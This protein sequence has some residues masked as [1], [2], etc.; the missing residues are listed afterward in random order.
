MLFFHVFVSLKLQKLAVLLIFGLAVLI[1][2]HFFSEN[3]YIAILLE[4]CLR[5][6]TR[7][8]VNFRSVCKADVWCVMMKRCCR[9]DVEQ[10]QASGVLTKACVSF[11]RDSTLPDAARYVQDNIRFH[12]SHLACLIHDC[13]AT[14]SHRV[15][16]VVVQFLNFM[17]CINFSRAW[18]S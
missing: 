14:V 18:C 4:R 15:S 1:L 9:E 17:H 3:K 13:N 6:V 12:G 10:W 8:L 16:N 5:L 2:R 11:S 7:A